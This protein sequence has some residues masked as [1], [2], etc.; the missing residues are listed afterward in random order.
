MEWYTEIIEGYGKVVRFIVY[1]ISAISGIAL[2]I[3]VIT[4]FVDVVGRH[5]GEGIKGSIDIIRLT[6]VIAMGGAI[7]YTTAVKGHIAVE[8]LFRRLSKS[9]RII[10]DTIIRLLILALFISI[11]YFMLKYGIALYNSGEVTPTAQIPIFWVPFWMALC[12]GI[13]ALVKVYHIFRPGK[14]LI[15]P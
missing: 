8:F 2:L 12:F 14:E 10:L 15:K 5:F 11:I 1:V 9:I 4:V 6:S 13:T 3:T 7:P